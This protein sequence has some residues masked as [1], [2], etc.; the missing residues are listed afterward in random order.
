MKKKIITKAVLAT[1]TALCGFSGCAVMGPTSVDMGRAAYAEVINRTQDEQMLLAIVKSR[2][3]ESFTLL[4]V[5]SVAANVRFKA[6]V[7][8][9]VGYG[10]SEN[11]AGQLVPFA[12]GV[13]YEENPTIT[14]SP[15]YGEAYFRQIMTPIPLDIV[16][17]VCRS[18][19]DSELSITALTNRI[20]DMRNPDFI[21]SESSKSCVLFHR[22]IKL[23]EELGNAGVLHWHED[24][25]KKDSF[26][27]LI[28]A[29]APTFSEK[30]GEYLTLLGLPVPA[31]KTQDIV[32]P[33]HFGVRGK[34]VDGVAISTRSLYDLI[35]IMMG[36]IAVPQEHISSG[37]TL[38][39]PGPGLAGKGIRIHGSTHKPTRAAIAVRH[40]GYWFYIEDSD[41]RTKS[42]FVL[43]R[44]LWAI[45][46]STTKESTSAPVL[47]IPLN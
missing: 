15:V 36:A 42:L 4:S 30:V 38:D 40:R 2:Y 12:G 24:S 5:N 26:V 7:G 39:Y 18:Q 6:N 37:L 29:Y 44:K 1:C 31:D 11:Y 34:G 16:V 41:M 32:I 27:I 8:V 21:D 9:E 14:Y 23:N 28:T 13:A 33:I 25:K 22:F 3:G 46:I 19:Q 10:S 35:E 20:N 45:A 47:T 17:L 43:L